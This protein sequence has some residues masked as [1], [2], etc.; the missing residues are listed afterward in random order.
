MVAMISVPVIL[1]I[2]VQAN[3][4]EQERRILGLQMENLYQDTSS[5]MESLASLNLLDNPFYVNRIM[6][7]IESR[8]TNRNI[9]VMVLD[10]EG[11]VL[12]PQNYPYKIIKPEEPWARHF[13][14]VQRI[15]SLHYGTPSF[16]LPTG[17]TWL[18]FVIWKLP[19][20]TF[21][22]WTTLTGYSNHYG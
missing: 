15:K 20:S 5:R 19:S 9:L 3:L 17:N 10:Q 13:Q 6:L 12:L 11:N 22:V 8:F 1:G 4:L 21:F 2:L 16:P 18:R 7:D 14:R